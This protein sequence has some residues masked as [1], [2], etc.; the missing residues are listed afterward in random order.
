MYILDGTS[1]QRTYERPTT[2]SIRGIASAVIIAADTRSDQKPLPILAT[3]TPRA[4]PKMAQHLNLLITSFSG[5]GLPPTL[6]LPVTKDTIVASIWDELWDRIP[7]TGSR[8]VL[9][10]T[11]NTHLPPTSHAPI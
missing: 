2:V 11:S 3:G 1:T 4:P 5:L 10:T 9:S 7:Q 8:L 6:A